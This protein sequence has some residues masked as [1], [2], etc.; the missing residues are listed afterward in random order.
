M[1]PNAKSFAIE[2]RDHMLATGDR[3]FKQRVLE[4]LK[5]HPIGAS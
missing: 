5:E 3:T 2:G 1:M 4:F